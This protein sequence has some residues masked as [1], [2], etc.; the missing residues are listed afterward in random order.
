MSDDAQPPE[1]RDGLFTKH[2]A[3]ILTFAASAMT[4]VFSYSQF[5]IAELEKAKAEAV[6]QTQKDKELE[7]QRIKDERDWQLRLGDFLLKNK[8]QIFS[9]EEHDVRQMRAVILSTFPPEIS[10]RLLDGLMRDS[11]TPDAARES[12]QEARQQ[13]DEQLNARTTVYVQYVA[14][15]DQPRVKAIIDKLRR[16][17][18]KVPGGEKV[19]VPVNGAE[20]RYYY[21]S[22]REAASAMAVWLGQELESQGIVPRVQR[23]ERLADKT[24][25]GIVEMWI[26]ALNP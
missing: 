20:V 9:S 1:P 5:K 10:A 22:D 8:A 15:R 7:L 12:W 6:A 13:S 26:P 4:T 14:A 2:S 25:P 19:T 16:R 24:T 21:D 11:A 3:A 18:Y 17:G 23:L